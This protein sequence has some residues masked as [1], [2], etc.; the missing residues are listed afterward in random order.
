[1]KEWD[2]EYSGPA[3]EDIDSIFCYIAITLQAPQAAKGQI[4]RIIY[5][6]S[7]LDTMPERYP[8]LEKKKWKESAL[9]R[10]NVDKYA[11]L[12]IADRETGAVSITRV[13]YGGQ[14]IDEALLSE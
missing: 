2:V 8:Y 3:E 9:R 7:K 5:E 6:A 14:D 12:Y 11:V 4:N 10:M 1:M 13:L